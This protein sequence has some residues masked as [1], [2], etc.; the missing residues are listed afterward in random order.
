MHST[1]VGV[2]V[3]KGNSHVQLHGVN[4]TR[5]QGLWFIFLIFVFI[6]FT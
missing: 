1:D 2:K 5:N 4:G 3:A 6:F